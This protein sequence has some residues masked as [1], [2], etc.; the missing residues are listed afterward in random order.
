MLAEE[1]A[2]HNHGS[3]DSCGVGEQSCRQRVAA[4]ADSDRTKVNCQHVER[5][6]VDPNIV[7]AVY[8]MVSDMAFI[9]QKTQ[10]YWPQ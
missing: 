2:A 8:L 10:P 9:K 6:L 7:A 4:A 1:S 3:D 5:R